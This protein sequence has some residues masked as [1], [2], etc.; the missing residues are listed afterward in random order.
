MKSN[1]R[2]VL[3]AVALAA[4]LAAQAQ[5]S[6]S[7]KVKQGDNLWRI[8]RKHHISV[9]S[10]VAAN[11][12]RNEGELK[13]NRK[14][15]IPGPSRG[16]APMTSQKAPARSLWRQGTLVTD[17]ICVRSTPG[18]SGRKLTVLD[19]DV[20]L[21]LTAKAKGWYQVRLPG[22]TEGWI[23]ADY[24]KAGKMIV[25]PKPVAAKK[26]AISPRKHKQAVK[27]ARKQ[28]AARKVATI[29]ARQRQTRLEDRRR[30]VVRLYRRQR[31]SIPPNTT[32]GSG[33]VVGTAY[34]YQGMPYRRGG[35]TS[36]SG[37]DCSGFTRYIYRKSGVNLPH[38]SRSQYG[39]GRPVSKSGLQKGDLVFF[40]TTR[41][42]ISHVG[43][44]AGNGKFIHASNH[45]RGV[46]VDSLG[47]AYYSKRY[48]GAKRVK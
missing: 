30:K 15:I 38:S 35:T 3:V 42:G 12:L 2:P 14:L 31:E 28:A 39:V 29:R 21:T 6:Q 33:S 36:R 10:L 46:T 45:S 4:V 27:A 5:A 32:G 44:Y 22:G 17:R 7:Y 47:S 13:L 19:S 40:R 48:V 26:M 43:I 8:A 41:R 20:K 9:D 34:A 16:K 24:V 37:F 1:S 18:Q 11:G 25:P 23:R